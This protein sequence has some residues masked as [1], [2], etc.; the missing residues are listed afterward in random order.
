[1]VASGDL[2]EA[3]ILALKA[4]G[5]PIGVWGVGT[6]LVTAHDDPALSGVYKLGCIRDAQGG[7][8]GKRKFSDDPEKATLPGILQV[9]RH[10]GESGPL[11][12]IIYD[13]REGPSDPGRR[14]DLRGSVRQIDL[15]RPV[16]RAG[17]VVAEPPD[18]EAARR[19]AR[20]Q[21]LEFGLTGPQS[22]PDFAVAMTPD[23]GAKLAG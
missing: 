21:L 20:E 3:A 7:W 10:Y 6:R 11:A 22:T 17:A 18:I 19:R 5:A 23:L 12:D 8:R 4:G 1:M 15:L 9:R 16:L 14:I 2:D 13:E